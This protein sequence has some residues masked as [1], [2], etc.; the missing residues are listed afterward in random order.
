MKIL[1]IALVIDL[2][3]GDSLGSLHPVVLIGR[4]TG[5]LESKLM[6]SNGLNNSKK[7]HCKRKYFKLPSRQSHKINGF[8]LVL[9]VTLVSYLSS[10]LLLKAVS[11]N[12][13]AYLLLSAFLISTTIA[14]KGL[15]ITGLDIFKSLSKNDINKARILLSKIVGRDTDDLNKTQIIRA[16]I[17]SLAENTI[18]G[19]IAPLF[20]AALGGAPLAMLYRSINTLDSMIGY[21]NDKYKDF[22]MVAAKLD[23]AA[24]FIPARIGLFFMWIASL[25]CKLNF[26]ETVRVSL[27]DGNKHQSPNSGLSEAAFAGALNIKLGG[28]AYYQG[29][30]RD[31]PQIGTGNN[32][33]ALENL[34][35]SIRLVSITTMLFFT[36]VLIIM[37][38]IK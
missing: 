2:I 31:L 11:F 25:T 13:F 19:I 14:F 38:V 8:I 29:I 9:I 16:T 26:K 4:L 15:I 34:T 24:N 36:G 35:D 20:Y 1:I 23:D 12:H 30:K 33:A 37:A 5:L 7:R 10:Y 22:G 18:D 6:P 17:E 3:I 27:R 32:E 21:K 28:T